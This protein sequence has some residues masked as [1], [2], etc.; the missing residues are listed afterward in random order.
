MVTCP[1][2]DSDDLDLLEKA[3]DDRRHIGCNNCGHDWWRGE[4]KPTAY[5]PKGITELRDSFHATH[6]VSPRRQATVD[7]LRDEFF[8]AHP[9]PDDDV[10]Q[11]W[12]RYQQVFSAEGLP[13]CN[14]RDL[15]DFANSD[16]GAHPGNMSV[17]NTAWNEL[18]DDEAA[19]RTRGAI[20]YLLYGPDHVPLEDRLTHLIDGP[21]ALEMRG[22]KEALLTKVLCIMQPT[23]FLPILIYTSPNGGKRE[24]ART[25]FG[26]ELPARDRTHSPIGRLITWSNDLLVEAAGPGFA[27]TQRISAFLWWAKDRVAELP[28]PEQTHTATNHTGKYRALSRWLAN[29]HTHEV[30][31]TFDQIEQILGFPLPPSSYNHPPHWHGYEGSAVARAIADAGWRATNVNLTARRVTFVRDH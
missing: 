30:H 13:H 1:K 25:V 17:F 8:A 16:T 7:T 19:E 14:P 18:G 10:Q 12:A 3:P 24:I 20:N 28:A 4:P 15:K 9:A 29:Q 23:R 5:Q 6:Q 22:F 11:Y 31:A 27:H 2:C 26:L 21:H